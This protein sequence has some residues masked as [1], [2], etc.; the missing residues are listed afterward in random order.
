[1]YIIYHVRVTFLTRIILLFK[2]PF[3]VNFHVIN[4][5]GSNFRHFRKTKENLKN[6]ALTLRLPHNALLLCSP[7]PPDVRRN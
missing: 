4:W 6:A 1:M 5:F 3:T 7:G 2:L